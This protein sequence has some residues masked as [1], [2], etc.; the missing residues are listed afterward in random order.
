MGS[1]S[2]TSTDNVFAGAVPQVY[3]SIRTSSR[4]RWP[5]ESQRKAKWAVDSAI[6]Y[7]QGT[8]LRGEIEA[9]DAKIQAHVVTIAK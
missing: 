9:R 8:P 2:S 4:T 1:A 3:R 5:R 6:A 7:C